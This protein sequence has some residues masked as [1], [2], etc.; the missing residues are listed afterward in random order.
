MSHSAAYDTALS[1]KERKYLKT[2]G[3]TPSAVES[4]EIQEKRC[5]VDT[6]HA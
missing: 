4:F 5:N 6:P 2:Y 3:L 1:D